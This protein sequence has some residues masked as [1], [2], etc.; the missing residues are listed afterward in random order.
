MVSKASELLPEPDSP[1]NTTSSSRGMSRSTFLRLCSRA[2]RMAMTRRS[3]RAVF[4]FFAFLLGPASVIGN[5]STPPLVRAGLVGEAPAERSKNA[6]GL[7]VRLGRYA[8]IPLLWR[9]WRVASGEWR[10]APDFAIRHSL[11][12]APVRR[13]VGAKPTRN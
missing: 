13:G 12:A 5:G 9:E 4:L 10:R 3:A 2:P 11:F 7:P 6:A 1:V 8:R